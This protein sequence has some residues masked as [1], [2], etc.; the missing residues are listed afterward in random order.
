MPENTKKSTTPTSINSKIQALN[1][2][3]AWFYSDDFSL[4]EAEKNFKSATLLAKEIESDLE[5]LKND[6]KL[7]G[8]DFSK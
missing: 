5:S 3:V 8:R 4:D 1:S 2:K 7:L 6:I